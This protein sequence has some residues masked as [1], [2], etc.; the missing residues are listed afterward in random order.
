MN[1]ITHIYAMKVSVLNFIS[2][3]FNIDINVLI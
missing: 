1:S 3:V 2:Q